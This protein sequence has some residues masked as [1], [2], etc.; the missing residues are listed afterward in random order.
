M[1]FIKRPALLVALVLV[2]AFWGCGGAAGPANTTGAPPPSPNASASIKNVV[3]IIMQNGSFDHFFGTFPGVDGI[4]PGVPGFSQ[5]DAS[6]NTVNPT[7][8]KTTT[9]PDLP[10]SR[11]DNLA[12]WNKGAMDG[13]A[14]LGGAIA[15]GFYDNTTPGVDQLW[16]MA[17]Q[18]AIS[19]R[20]FSSVM[21]DAPTNQL[22]M[23]AA[24]DN[25]TPFS[26]QPAFG[27]CNNDLKVD[28]A[29]TFQNVG[30]QL[31]AKGMSWAWFNE[32]LGQCGHYIPQENPFQ[33]FTSTHASAN[34]RDFSEFSTAL[35]S[36]TLPALSFVQP[37]PAHS[38]HPGSGDVTAS[39]TWLMGVI[40]QVQGST[41][42]NNAAIIVVWDA[43]GGW[44]DHVPPPQVD[45]QGLGFRVPILVISPFA[46]KGYV[47]HVQMDDVS[48]LRFIQNV[49]G[50][51]M[52]NPRN[53]T[54]PDL[55]DFF[56][57]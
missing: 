30:D 55:T 54:S 28:S 36:G 9:P 57:F 45:D 37:G 44:W 50:L 23:V 19:D 39:L 3:V 31:T 18:F 49:Y 33:Y 16:S 35:A 11:E 4:R 41:V 13:F 24:S 25:G 38:A 15:L 6:G 56:N 2:A 26:L 1:P 5:L 40:Q 34:M 8:L 17:Q 14:K 48:I 20:F 10:H 22:M 12:Q 7:L 46:K 53:Q 32:D 47:S 43:A 52:L 42:W 27:P 29:Y 21:G 51:P